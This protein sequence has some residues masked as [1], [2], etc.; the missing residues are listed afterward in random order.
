[1]IIA[2]NLLEK[3][4]SL[5]PSRDNRATAA[6]VKNLGPNDDYCARVKTA[7]GKSLDVLREPAKRALLY[8][9]QERYKISLEDKG[10]C[11]SLEEIKA[12]LDALLG[13]GSYIVMNLVE[14]ELED[15]VNNKTGAC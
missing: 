14:K 9:L 15:L 13:G 8:H 10:R 7:L 12:A 1:M 4:A 11:L 2:R 5:L 3:E 6:M